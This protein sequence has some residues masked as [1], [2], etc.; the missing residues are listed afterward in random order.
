M[1]KY[2]S[3]AEV[4]EKADFILR[5]KVIDPAGWLRREPEIAMK[6]VKREVE[7]DKPLVVIDPVDP[8]RNVAAN[9]SWEKY[10]RLYFKADE[11]LQRPSL[12]FFFPT[13]KTGG[14]D[15]LA[16]LRRKGGTH[17]ITLLFDVPEMVDDLL[18]PQLERSSRGV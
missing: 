9:L 18:F 17:L 3:F 16:E 11:F 1:I 10:G 4:L 2:G 6:T 13:G 8:R 15:Y 7:E 14:G 12:E 5:Q